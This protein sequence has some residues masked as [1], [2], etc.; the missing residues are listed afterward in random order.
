MLTGAGWCR[1]VA[2]MPAAR[3]SRFV[4]VDQVRERYTIHCGGVV[5]PGC[6]LSEFRGGAT[7][8]DITVFASNCLA[9]Q[10]WPW[11][12]V[13][14]PCQS[15]DHQDGAAQCDAIAIAASMDA[16]RS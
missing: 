9:T 7:A 2:K 14:Q 15:F 3:A 5:Q 6:T 8:S 4:L 10:V 1:S 13:D 16:V 12:W 11:P